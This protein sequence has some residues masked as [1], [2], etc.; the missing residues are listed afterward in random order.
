MSRE[1]GNQAA[2]PDNPAEAV[3]MKED[4]PSQSTPEPLYR[5]LLNSEIR[6]IRLRPGGW[7]DPIA[8]DLITI[9]LDDKPKFVALSY[10]ITVNLFQGLR[11]LRDMLS[12]VD[13]SS[14][15]FMTERLDNFHIWADAICINQADD[16]EKAHQIVRMRD[17]YSSAYRVCAWLG[18][19]TKEEEVNIRRLE[20]MTQ[21]LELDESVW[22]SYFH[23]LFGRSRVELECCADGLVKL[24]ARSWF[25]RVWVI[26]EVAL[27]AQNPVLLAGGVWMNLKTLNTLRGIITGD[28]SRF[29]DATINRLTISFRLTY[30]VGLRNAY[31]GYIID[32]EIFNMDELT[33]GARLDI[34]LGNTHGGFGATLPHDYIYGILGLVCSGKLPDVLQPDYNKPLAQVYQEYTRFI[35][36]ATGN[37]SILFRESSSLEGSP[38]WVPDF[39]AECTAVWQKPSVWKKPLADVPNSASFSQS[40]DKIILRGLEIA[41]CSDVY[42]PPGYD[43]ADLHENCLAWLQQLD[44]FLGEV[45]SITQST[46]DETLERWL[47]LKRTRNPIETKRLY[48][49]I[50]HDKV[51]VNWFDQTIDFR[52]LLQTALYFYPTLITSS[53]IVATL[54]RSDHVSQPGDVLVLVR[55]NSNVILLRP[56]ERNDLY[57]FL[58]HCECVGFEYH[59][60]FFSN[61][62]LKEF[63]VA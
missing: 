27:A 48:K 55:G 36:E 51:H 53:G 35:I 18:E 42:T 28:I 26:Q 38:S 1:G 50:I 4:A 43:L 63:V 29:G 62:V 16:H 14:G 52:A 34:V 45:S 30:L 15:P 21:S 25:S 40:G 31:T 59:D 47:Q 20:G 33:L 10:N 49:S 39:R 61:K 41:S 58:G 8:C 19:N 60:E 56:N 17:I 23:D 13:R 7:D 46:K 11:R 44:I 2:N 5:P 37:L 22:R 32:E 9:R 57:T 3:R 12:Q 6:L 54:K 24:I